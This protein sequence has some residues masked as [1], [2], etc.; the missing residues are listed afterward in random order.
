MSMCAFGA[1]SGLKTSSRRSSGSWTSVYGVR[2][3]VAAKMF[4]M[5]S[6]T[7][8]QTRPARVAAQYCRLPPASAL[9]MASTESARSSPRNDPRTSMSAASARNCSK[10]SK[11]DS[12]RPS[13]LPYARRPVDP[14]ASTCGAP[15][16]SEDPALRGVQVESLAGATPVAPPCAG[17]AL[18]RADAGSG[19]RACGRRAES[20]PRCHLAAA[21][22]CPPSAASPPRSA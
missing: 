5:R 10:G 2:S 8:T 13:V 9:K 22:R 18:H 20:R 3:A 6:S 12:T 17:R 4:P 16:R 21:A 15:D 7:R 11:G 19:R 14:V 1:A